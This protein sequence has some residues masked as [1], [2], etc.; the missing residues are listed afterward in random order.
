MAHNIGRV[1]CAPQHTR[2]PRACGR[3]APTGRPRRPARSAPADRNCCHPHAAGG[4]RHSN[5]HGSVRSCGRK[6]RAVS[7]RR[8]KL[9][10]AGVGRPR[11]PAAADARAGNACKGSQRDRTLLLLRAVPL[12]TTRDGERYA[13]PCAGS[14][15]PWSHR[16]HLE[17][18]RRRTCSAQGTSRTLKSAWLWRQPAMLPLT[19]ACATWEERSNGPL[20]HASQGIPKRRPQRRGRRPHGTPLYGDAPNGT[21][22]APLVASVPAVDVVNP[23]ALMTPVAGAAPRLLAD[24]GGVR[25][26]RRRTPPDSA[27]YAF[28]QHFDPSSV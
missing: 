1:N 19:R 25:R 12:E 6:A 2:G 10:A 8:V 11:F 7:S 20:G 28:R 5:E 3:R 27:S 24:G 15:G 14:G 4:E 18:R 16:F 22:R 17:A 26:R 21:H 13:V 23:P 9:E